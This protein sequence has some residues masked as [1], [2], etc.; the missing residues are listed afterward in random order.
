LLCLLAKSM[1]KNFSILCF[2][3]LIPGSWMKICIMSCILKRLGG[4]T[5]LPN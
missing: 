4:A 3:F 2:H 5:F 1:I